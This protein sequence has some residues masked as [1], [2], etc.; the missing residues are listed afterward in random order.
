MQI[1]IDNKDIVIE[2]KN[3]NNKEKVDISFYII[4]LEVFFS[5]KPFLSQIAEDFGYLKPSY[6]ETIFLKESG[7]Q[8][9]AETRIKVPEKLQKVNVFVQVSAGEM[10]AGTTYFS[11]SLKVQI[12]E[13]FG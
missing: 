4:D 5:K 2:H 8:Q 7:E 13:N 6:T 11:T 10:K 1:K 12:F 9:L 3:I